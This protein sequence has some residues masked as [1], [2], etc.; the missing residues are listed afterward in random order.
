VGALLAQLNQ[1]EKALL[2]AVIL[3]LFERLAIQTQHHITG[4][5]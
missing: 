4:L 5:V 2:S 3:A 1:G